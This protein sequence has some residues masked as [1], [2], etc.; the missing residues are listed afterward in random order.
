MAKSYVQLQESEGHL[1][2]ATS[3]IY[4]AYLTNDL[5]TGDN[6]TELMRKA[7]KEALQLADAIDAAVIADSE[8][9]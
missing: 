4:S 9:E 1:L 3:R 6:E 7:I 8:V 5:Y 2:A